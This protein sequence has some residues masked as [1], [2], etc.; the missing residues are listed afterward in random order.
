[1]FNLDKEVLEKIKKFAE[2]QFEVSEGDSYGL[3]CVPTDTVDIINPWTDPT[4]RFP[5]TDEQA[6]ETYGRERVEEFCK[7]AL[8]YVSW[9]P[10][11][12]QYFEN[13]KEIIIARVLG[14][15]PDKHSVR[16]RV[17]DEVSVFSYTEPWT[18]LNDDTEMILYVGTSMWKWTKTWKI[19]DRYSN[20][21]F[22]SE[23]AS[24][25]KKRS[26]MKSDKGKISFEMI[27]D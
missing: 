1:M 2:W 26:V 23:R 22:N 19:L 27:W 15:Y 3:I 25:G 14:A 20:P 16:R 12:R 9:C 24:Y 4:G 8:P 17:L 7:K 11:F 5:L 18:V 21:K 10:V 6:V 13:D